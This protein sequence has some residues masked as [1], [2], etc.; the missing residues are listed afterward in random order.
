MAVRQKLREF[1]TR[2][3]PH[4]TFRNVT[5]AGA[6]SILALLTTISES[7]LNIYSN[8]T[9]D[10][11]STAD[12]DKPKTTHVVEHKSSTTEVLTGEDNI[13][14]TPKM[15]KLPPKTK[16]DIFNDI[17]EL[18]HGPVSETS[19]S[20]NPYRIMNATDEYA[21]V[22]LG[23]YQSDHTMDISI[24][25]GERW[26]GNLPPGQWIVLDE[27]YRWYEIPSPVENC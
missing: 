18:I 25:P 20:T 13:T 24:G 4:L 5:I 26:V 1:L 17:D 2:V 8:L 15:L 6:L 23:L 10:N 14:I 22:T 27:S 7:S 3:R 9:G 11:P 16:D 21:H 12:P 19:C